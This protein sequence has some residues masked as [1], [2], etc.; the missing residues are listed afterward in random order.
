MANGRWVPPA[1]FEVPDGPGPWLGTCDGQPACALV[2]PEEAAALSSHRVE[3]WFDGLAE[4]LDGRE[5]GGEWIARPWDLVARNA[6]HLARDFQDDG[7]VG[8]SNRHLA[9]VALVGPADR[10]FIH[11]TARIDPY[12]VFDTTAGPITVAA[13]VHV[14]PFTRIE[15]P[16]FVGRD[17]QLF[18]ANLRGGITIGPNCRIGGEV[19]ATIIHGFTNKY[20]EGFLGHAYVGEW[21]N[22]GAITSNSDLRN[23]YGEVF[24]PLGGEPVATGQ[25]KVGCFIGDHT[26]TGLGSMLNT[27]TAIG[28]MCNVLPAGPLLPKH[29][30][31]F[32]AVLYG[33]GGARVPPGADVRHGEDGH[34]TSRPGVH[35]GRAA[36]LP[37]PL[38]AD[39]PGARARVP[40]GARPPR[41]SLAG[42]RGPA[43][44]V[45]GTWLMAD[46]R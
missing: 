15:G 9:T 38:R 44:I 39:P 31:S 45:A 2:G 13:G 43:L 42:R 18:R 24:V 34:G 3:D 28:V 6:D 1:V 33:Q 36:T 10:L 40:E 22:L 35:R 19:E 25:A 23:D 20:H 5:L 17:T 30:P 21:V 26:R 14:Q 32:T 37:R 29:V 7:K 8:L 27:G 12:T 41:R 4:R 46:G 16:A 11:E